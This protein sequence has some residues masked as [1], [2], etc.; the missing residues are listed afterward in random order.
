LAHDQVTAQKILEPHYRST[1]ERIK[2]YPVVLVPQDTTELD[3]TG[4]NDIAGLGTL[5]YENRRGLYLHPSLAITPQRLSLGL[6]DSWSWTR[7]FED[8]EKESIRWIE[9]FQ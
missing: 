9:G 5:N 8:A 4:K 2:H 1:L 3:Y 7:P 6:L